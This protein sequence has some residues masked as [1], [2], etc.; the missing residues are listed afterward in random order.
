MRLV[1]WIESSALCVLTAVSVAAQPA[2]GSRALVGAVR[3]PGG[4]PIEGAVIEIHGVS[5]RSDSR[6]AFRLFTSNVDTITVGI[7]RLGYAPLSA[8]IEARNR[9]W[10]TLVVELDPIPQELAAVKATAAKARL[11]LRDIDD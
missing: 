4:L 7:R 11:G 1:C 6:G 2:V 3:D 5:A 9:Q 10:D 8:L